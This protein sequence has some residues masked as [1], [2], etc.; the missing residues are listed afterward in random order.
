[1]EVILGEFLFLLN[2]IFTCH[3]RS[4]T[5]YFILSGGDGNLNASVLPVLKTGT[6]EEVVGWCFL[7]MPHQFPLSA[8]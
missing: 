3:G 5:E 4:T 6:M 2:A 7:H 8:S 1:M